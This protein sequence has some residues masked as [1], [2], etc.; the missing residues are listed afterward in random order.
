MCSMP[1]VAE[2][3]SQLGLSYLADSMTRNGIDVLV[4]VMALLVVS[5]VVIVVVAVCH[6]AWLLFSSPHTTIT[7][8]MPSSGTVVR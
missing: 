6:L 8:V 3:L 1:P 2:F 5:V 7:F 4:L